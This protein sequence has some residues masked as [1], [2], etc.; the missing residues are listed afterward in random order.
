MQWV[1]DLALFRAEAQVQSLAWELPYAVRPL[2]KIFFKSFL[3]RKGKYKWKKG[4]IREVKVCTRGR[5]RQA[6]FW[7]KIE[8]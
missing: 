5:D 1:K 2:N 8:I 7:G 4:K 3:N 6:E